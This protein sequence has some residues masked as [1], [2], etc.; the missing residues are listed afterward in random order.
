[1]WKEFISRFG[2]TLYEC[3]PE[4]GLSYLIH[5]LAH[6]PLFENKLSSASLNSLDSASSFSKDIPAQKKLSSL[7][8]CIGELRLSLV[9][10]FD[11]VVN[12]D[13]QISGLSTKKSLGQSVSELFSICSAIELSVDKS[14]LE[15]EKKQN[16]NIQ[17]VNHLCENILRSKYGGVIFDS[18]VNDASKSTPS[19]AS[20]TSEIPTPSPST[21]L[22]PPAFYLQNS[23]SSSYKVNTPET[24]VDSVKI[25]T[26]YP[27]TALLPSAFYLQN[28]SSS[29]KVNT[30][31]THVDSVKGEKRNEALKEKEKTGLYLY[32]DGVCEESTP[33]QDQEKLT[34]EAVMED[35]DNA[36]KREEELYDYEEEND[37]VILLNKI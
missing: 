29:H 36:K 37:D 30:P 3:R 15:S 27:S 7:P 10:F 33:E 19:K 28:S 23:S 13:S 35:R 2:V 1:L 11:A 21:A 8:D 31:E 12:S 9:C 18:R 6:H 25:P 20:I 4:Y 17:I 5:L 16:Y 26:P 14:S 32:I 22:L 24:H 34:K